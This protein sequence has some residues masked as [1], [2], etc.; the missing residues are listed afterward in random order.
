VKKYIIV[1]TIYVSIYHRGRIITV[2]GVIDPLIG[3]IA[4]SIKKRSKLPV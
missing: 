4:C 1:P 3:G 2:F